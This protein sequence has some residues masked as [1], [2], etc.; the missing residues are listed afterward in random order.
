MPWFIERRKGEY[1]VIKGTKASPGKQV[2]CHPTRDKA[3]AHMQALYA[4]VEDA[5]KKDIE[6]KFFSYKTADDTWRWTSISSVAIEDKEEEIVSEKAYDDAIEYALKSNIF[7]ELDVI[8][9]NGTEVGDCDMMARLG[10][11][12]VESGTWRNTDKARM[13]RTKISED[14]DNWGVSIQFRFDPKQFDGKVYKGGIQITKRAVLPRSMAASFGTAIAIQGGHEKMFKM[15]E[16]HKK[17]LLEMGFSEE[18]VA[19]FAEKNKDTDPNVKNKDEDKEKVEVVEKT[20]V[21]EAP[22]PFRKKLMSFLFGDPQ[23]TQ[24]DVVENKT[25]DPAKTSVEVKTEEKKEKEE[26][27]VEVEEKT[28]EKEVEEKPDNNEE[29]Q[30]ILT[31][32]FASMAE[33]VNKAIEASVLPLQE[34]FLELEHRLVESEKSIEEKVVGRLSELPPIAKVRP[35]FVAPVTNVPIEG[36][37]IKEEDKTQGQIFK[38][39]IEGLVANAMRDSSNLK[40]EI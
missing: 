38:E 32:M 13:V 10:F 4:N 36:H 2:D 15:T 11:Q 19:S 40:L 1:C 30:K 35:T 26:P 8:H 16:E 17:V 12:L 22:E 21:T 3:F 27:K 20:E 14:P 7:G 24:S 5:G 39:A 28:E 33:E 29:M 6:S 31:P 25:E 18:D 9:V 23:T 34:K 37:V